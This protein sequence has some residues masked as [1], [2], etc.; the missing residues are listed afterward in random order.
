MAISFDIKQVG[1]DALML[2][3]AQEPSPG[4]CTTIGSVA[5]TIEQHLQGDLID[6]VPSFTSLLLIFDPLQLSHIDLIKRIRAAT[7]NIEEGTTQPGKEVRLPVYYSPESGPDLE[8]LADHAGL[9]IDEVI[10]LHSATS[11]H[12]Y[13]IGFAP[14]FAYLGDV[15]ARISRPRLDTPRTHVPQ[16]AVAI[17]NRQT[18]V[19]PAASPG[20]W[21]LIGLCPTKMFDAY[22]DTKMPIQVGD[23]VKFEP[24]G[25]AEF[26]KLGGVLP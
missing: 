10:S 6:M 2:Y 13:A 20:G 4:L 24:V 14:G 3:F 5:A 23:S 25:R 21:N 1:A 11:Y 17:A 15:D 19:Y 12:V 9:G 22:A 26:L 7:C 8:A 18:A 16:G